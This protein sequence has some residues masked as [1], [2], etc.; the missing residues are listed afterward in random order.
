MADIP[1]P[2]KVKLAHAESRELESKGVLQ[3]PRGP[4]TKH[5]N[6]Q[7]Q[8]EYKQDRHNIA[9]RLDKS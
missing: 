9:T 1:S 6:V 4:T 2:L 8:Q 7:K 3:G 5:E